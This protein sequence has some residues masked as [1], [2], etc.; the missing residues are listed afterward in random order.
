MKK[1]T[2]Q[3]TLD[4]H[5]PS[6]VEL[7]VDDRVQL[8]RIA[9]SPHGTIAERSGDLLEP[10]TTTLDLERGMYFFRTLS[11]ATLRV[12]CGG[13]NTAVRTNDD[14]K[15]PWPDPPTRLPPPRSSGDELPGE[16][17]SFTVV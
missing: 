5:E 15:D 11:D 6:V 3:V 17:P 16:R 14:D 8:D 1:K 7:T 4:V 2:L 9:P 10:G 13:V 12:V